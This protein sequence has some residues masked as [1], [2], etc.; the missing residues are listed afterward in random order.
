MTS[1]AAAAASSTGNTLSTHPANTAPIGSDS[2]TARE[3]DRDK[4]GQW[5]S[6]QRRPAGPVRHRGQQETGD[7]G[8][9][10][11]VQHLVGMPIDWRKCRRDPQIA[12]K[13]R[14]PDQDRQRGLNRACQEEWPEAIAQNG[15]SRPGAPAGF[16]DHVSAYRLEAT[17][18]TAGDDG[19][20]PRLIHYRVAC[21]HHP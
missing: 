17:S 11:A 3:P 16:A 5:S 2:R 8:G 18:D 10:I 1:R 15:R 9:E 4:R 7:D 6:L 12:E 21:N 13:H 19:S 20:L 14:E